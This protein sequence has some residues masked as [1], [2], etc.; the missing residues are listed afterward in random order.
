VVLKQIRHVLFKI[1]NTFSDSLLDRLI[2]CHSV[3]LISWNSNNSQQSFVFLEITAT[4][5]GNLGYTVFSVTAI[6]LPI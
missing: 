4:S 1:T 5:S 3:V 2:H 6:M